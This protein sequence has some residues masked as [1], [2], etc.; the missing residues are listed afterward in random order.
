V[1]ARVLAHPFLGIDHQQRG[2]GSCRTGDHVLEEL[3]MPR[4]IDDDVVAA[5]RLE[6]AARGVDGDALVLLVGE[7]I[8]QE[9]VLERLA[10]ALAFPPDA[11]E[12]ALGQRTGVGEQPPDQRALAVVDMADDDDVHLV[13]IGFDAIRDRCGWSH[14]ILPGSAARARRWVVRAAAHMERA[15]TAGACGGLQRLMAITCIL[16]GAVLPSRACHPA[17]GPSARRCCAGGRS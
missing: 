9:G 17:C 1:P 7:R 12:L 2:F 14:G 8:E 15:G 6:E 5:A 3:D 11:L 16:R 4:R 13:A 10:G